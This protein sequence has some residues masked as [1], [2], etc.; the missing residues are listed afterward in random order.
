VRRGAYGVYLQ[1]VP[2]QEELFRATCETWITKKARPRDGL[3]LKRKRLHELGDVHFLNV[4][5]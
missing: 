5:F 4:R 3:L 1:R 2:R